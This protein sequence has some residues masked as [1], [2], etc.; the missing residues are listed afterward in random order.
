MIKEDLRSIENKVRHAFDEGYELGKSK[1]S[2]TVSGLNWSVAGVK[3]LQPISSS[4]VTVMGRHM[5]IILI[6]IVRTAVQEWRQRNE[7]SC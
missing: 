5:S 1:L 7:V 4:A 2:D 6:S 3:V